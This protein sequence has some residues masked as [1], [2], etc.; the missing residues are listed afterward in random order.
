MSYSFRIAPSGADD[1]SHIAERFDADAVQADDQRDLRRLCGCA[2][3]V[4]HRG[5]VGRGCAFD[6]FGQNYDLR[7]AGC[8]LP[9][10][11]GIAVERRRAPVRIF[12]GECFGRK[13][14]G[15]RQSDARRRSGEGM[16]QAD[17]AAGERG[18]RDYHRQDQ[19]ARRSGRPGDGER[20][21]DQ[22]DQKS[23]APNSGDGGYLEEREHVNLRIGEAEGGAVR[24][25][26][27]Q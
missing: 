15:G 26:L 20:R 23:D 8:Q 6:L 3:D 16:L 17:G 14:V 22:R 21:G 11:S 19:D 25:N 2:E 1:Q 10:H 18:D 27:R 12:S 9:D 13:L 24:G 4:D 7:A 5:G